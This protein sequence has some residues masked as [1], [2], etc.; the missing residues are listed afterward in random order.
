DV[1]R[2]GKSLQ[3]PH[4]AGQLRTPL[5]L[6]ER[7]N[8][9]PRSVLRLERAVVLAYDEFDNVVHEAAEMLDVVRL[10][11]EWGN[12]EV[13]VAGRRMA[14]HDTRIIV[15]GKQCSQVER[16]VGEAL[17]READVLEDER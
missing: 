16:A 17:R 5:A 6:D 9:A 8:V 4:Q 11:E 13:Q 7:C 3:F 2:I 10:V 15:L 1:L 12:Q 14:E